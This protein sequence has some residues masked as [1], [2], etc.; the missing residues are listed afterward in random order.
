MGYP[1]GYNLG[2]GLFVQTDP[3][4]IIGGGFT[5]VSTTGGDQYSIPLMFYREQSGSH[6]WWLKYVDTW[7]GYYP[8]SWYNSSGIADKNAMIDYGGEIINDN[9]GGIHTT[10][11]MGSGHFSNEGWQHSAYT[12]HITYV[13]MTNVTRNASNLIPSI[14][15]SS[16]YDLS[17]FLSSDPNWVN[18]FYFGGPGRVSGSTPTSKADLDADGKADIMWEHS[19]GSLA[20]WFMNGTNV[21]QSVGMG[22][23]DPAWKIVGLGDLDGDGKSD[24]V[25]EHNSGALAVWF[26]NGSNVRQSVGMGSVDPAWRISGSGDLDGDGKADIVWEHTSGALAIWFM[27]GS[28][29]RQSVG[30]GAVDPAWKIVGSGDLDGDGKSDILWEHASGALAIWFMNGSNVRQSVGIGGVDPAWK[31]VGSGDFDADGKSDILWEH[32]SGSLALWFMNGSNLRQS[33]GMGAVAPAWSV[34]NY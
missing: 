17:L 19:S 26:M 30:I 34:K 23:V 11:D 24:I 33:I 16:Y 18:Y 22:S 4:V 5:N 13:D 10:T 9:I 2:A 31:I 7:V 20:A 8:N 27:N 15:N 28:S 1:G 14:T 6:N 32:T 29:V 12:R 25:W 3:S 21:R